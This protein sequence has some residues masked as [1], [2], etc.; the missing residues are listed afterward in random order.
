MIVKI[1]IDNSKHQPH[2]TYRNLPTRSEVAVTDNS[3]NTIHARYTMF[4]ITVK[5]SQNAQAH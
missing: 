3:T 5:K 4:D 2:H 1:N